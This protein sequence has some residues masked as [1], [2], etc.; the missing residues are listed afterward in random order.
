[1]HPF[2]VGFLTILI[3]NLR[4]AFV[5]TKKNIEIIIMKASMLLLKNLKLFKKKDCIYL[6]NPYPGKDSPHQRVELFS[7]VFHS[8]ILDSQ[9]H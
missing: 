8:R 5:G 7:F 3:T 4:L 2:L 6:L 1:M 9:N